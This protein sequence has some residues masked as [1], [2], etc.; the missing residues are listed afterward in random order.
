MPRLTGYIRHRLALFDPTG[1]Y[2]DDVILGPAKQPTEGKVFGNVIEEFFSACCQ[3]VEYLNF[4]KMVFVYDIGKSRWQA[5]FGRDAL[6]FGRDH[7]TIDTGNYVITVDPKKYRIFDRAA[8]K[9]LV[10]GVVRIDEQDMKDILAA[11]PKSQRGWIRTR[12]GYMVV[13]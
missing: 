8:G 10:N 13:V 9:P 5:D 4:T 2:L 1:F 7:F 3:D 11:A 6:E 12:L